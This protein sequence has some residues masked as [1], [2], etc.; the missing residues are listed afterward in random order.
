VSDPPPPPQVDPQPDSAA[1]SKVPDWALAPLKASLEYL[2]DEATVFRATMDGLSYTASLHELAVGVQDLAKSFGKES[3]LT[4]E[5]MERYRASAELAKAILADKKDMIAAH[6]LIGFWAAVEVLVEDLDVSFLAHDATLLLSD[7][8]GDVKVAFRDFELLSKED[9]IRAVLPLLQRRQSREEA[10]FE[11]QLELIGL[12]GP[13]PAPTRTAMR[14]AWQLRNVIV[15][16]R[17]IADA[18]LVA[19][20]PQLDNRY[21]E[22]IVEYVRLIGERLEAKFSVLPLPEGS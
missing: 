22:A 13:I 20:C 12:S 17:G 2:K 14:E 3:T 6:T 10:P 11:G 21:T 15:H 5:N 7:R 4:A 19:L 8:V 1:S 16:R 9:R 18:R